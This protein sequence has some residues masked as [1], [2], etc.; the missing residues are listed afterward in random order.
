MLSHLVS[1]LL[2]LLQSSHLCTLLSTLLF[3]PLQSWAKFGEL[4]GVPFPGIGAGRGHPGL[5]PTHRGIAQPECLSNSDLCFLYTPVS[6][7]APGSCHLAQG[8]QIQAL[9]PRQQY[10]SPGAP[11]SLHWLE[12]SRASPR[13]EMLTVFFPV[14]LHTSFSAFH[15]V[16]GSHSLW[17]RSAILTPP[18][19]CLVHGWLLAFSFLP[20]AVTFGISWLPATDLP[21]SQHLFKHHASG[22][23]ALCLSNLFVIWLQIP[24]GI[25]LPVRSETM[26]CGWKKSLNSTFSLDTGLPKS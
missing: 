12:I 5:L 2:C 11:A 25:L 14:T 13:L 19:R 4:P 7:L 8:R 10:L 6:S 26:P 18:V 17:K 16:L 21:S 20:A 9:A 23:N 24:K 3:L 22:G 1:L 15:S